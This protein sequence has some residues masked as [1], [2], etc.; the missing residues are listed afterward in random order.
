MDQKQFTKVLNNVQ[1]WKTTEL[2]IRYTKVTPDFLR[3]VVEDISKNYTFSQSISFIKR[4]AQ[5][6]YLVNKVNFEGD[7]KKQESYTKRDIGF[8]FDGTKKIALSSEI[9]TDQKVDITNTENLIVRY[10]YRMS[11]HIPGLNWVYDAT[12][13]HNFKNLENSVIFNTVKNQLYTKEPSKEHFLKLIDNKL[14]N[15]YELEIEY[16]PSSIGAPDNINFKELEMRLPTLIEY[17]NYVLVINQIA[18]LLGR[19]FKSFKSVLPQAVTLTAVSYNTIY[20]PVGWYL[21][22]KTD[23]YRGIAYIK[24]NMIIVI[25]AKYFKIYYCRDKVCKPRKELMPSNKDEVDNEKII[26]SLAE[27]EKKDSLFIVDCEIVDNNLYIFDIIVYESINV[28]KE[29]F[30]RRYGLLEKLS[31]ILETYKSELNLQVKYFRKISDDLQRSFKDVI[32]Y[33]PDYPHDGYMLINSTQ[34]YMQTKSYKIKTQNTID[35]YLFKCPEEFLNKFNFVKKKGLILYILYLTYNKTELIKNKIKPLPLTLKYFKNAGQTIPIHFSPNDY[36]DAY[37]Y[38]SKEDLGIYTIAE[39]DPIFD[40]DEEGNKTNFNRWNLIKIRDDKLLEPNYYGNFY[41]MGEEMWYANQN[42]LNIAK[43]H[44]PSSSYFMVQKSNI[45]YAQTAFNSFVKET[46]IKSN[47]NNRAVC[48][49][50][51]GK[52]QDLGRYLKQGYNNI[53]LVEVDKN[54][55]AEMIMR[56][57]ELISKN[58]PSKSMIGKNNIRILNTNLHNDH[59]IVLEKMRNITSLKNYSLVVCNLAI[60]YIINTDPHMYNFISLVNELVESGGTFIYTTNN[61][62]AIHEKFLSLESDTIELYENNILKYMIK[63]NY[64]EATLDENI[65]QTVDW[66]L[67]F[68][69]DLMTEPLMPHN[70]FN[71]LMKSRGFEVEKEGPFSDFLKDFNNDKVVLSDIDKEYIGYYYYCILK[72]E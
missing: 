70:K 29:D 58:S 3:N 42:P 4:M 21:T 72:K 18:S 14:I 6:A 44:L 48:D 47:H 17:N 43:M 16:L 28:S 1:D 2:E 30:D 54:A 45:Y 40:E 60:H 51:S 66:K 37:L 71:E 52:G 53:M 13:V 31:L 63:K 27:E 10:K 41:T 34:N 65:Y 67:L 55:I 49:L 22:H 59:R 38:Y 25:C 62:I 8:Y 5:D 39:M 56:L 57:P 68:N 69:N 64:K 11:Y 46:L 7:N 33:K 35:F 9:P 50:A 20:P 24:N 32:D 26:N 61:N 15:K 12:L 23:G 19:D 36:P